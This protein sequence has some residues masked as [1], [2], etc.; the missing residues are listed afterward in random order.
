MTKTPFWELVNK[1]LNTFLLSLIT[2]ATIGG[3]I[4]IWNLNT[5]L[6]QIKGQGENRDERMSTMQN[7]VNEMR[8]D[9]KEV[10]GQMSETR[11]RL[12]RLEDNAPVKKR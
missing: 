11:E 3:F 9:V 2:S 10:K 4:F 12:I 6:T 5:T 7:G 1:N 8:L